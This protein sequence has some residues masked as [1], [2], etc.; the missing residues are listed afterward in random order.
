MCRTGSVGF[1]KKTE[2]VLC[3]TGQKWQQLFSLV[4]DYQMICAVENDGTCDLNTTE[5]HFMKKH[6]PLLAEPYWLLLIVSNAIQYRYWY[7]LYPT[8]MQENIKQSIFSLSRMKVTCK[9]WL[10]SHIQWFVRGFR[11]EDD[12]LSGTRSCWN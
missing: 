2:A 4:C 7:I 12:V 9:T 10:F 5:Y 3:H 1:R 11:T 8:Y 6:H